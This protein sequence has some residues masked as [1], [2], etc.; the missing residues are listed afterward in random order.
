MTSNLLD[1]T[2]AK[3][4]HMKVPNFKRFCKFIDGEILSE[5]WHIGDGIS[6]QGKVINGPG[7]PGYAGMRVIGITLQSDSDALIKVRI[8]VKRHGVCQRTDKELDMCKIDFRTHKPYMDLA[9]GEPGRAYGMYSN[10]NNWLG[11]YCTWR[12]DE[13]QLIFEI[14]QLPHSERTK[15]NTGIK[16]EIVVGFVHTKISH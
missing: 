14:V 13:L 5:P 11:Q 8:S 2:N 7:V 6:V 4:F 9:N 3:I 15:C 12:G 10:N 16:K 1:F